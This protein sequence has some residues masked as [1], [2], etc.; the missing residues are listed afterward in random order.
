MS[1]SE[2]S[3]IE[4]ITSL[5]TNDGFDD[6]ALTDLKNDRIYGECIFCAGEILGRMKCKIFFDAKK[7]AVSA[8][9]IASFRETFSSDI[10]RGVYFTY[11]EAGEDA[12][13]EASKAGNRIVTIYTIDRK[14]KKKSPESEGKVNP[15]RGDAAVEGP[16]GSVPLET[17]K[18]AKAAAI[19]F[20]KKNGGRIERVV[21]YSSRQK[22]RDE[23]WIN[24]DTSF[25]HENWTLILNDIEKHELVLL[26]IPKNTFHAGEDEKG[27]KVRKD[28][29]TYEIKI[30]RE[31][32]TDKISKNSFKE[33]ILEVYK[34]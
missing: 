19:K 24:P 14:V 33:Y 17:A 13:K 22:E 28:K 32:M 6:I 3:R 18:F 23:Y 21:S 8:A 11:A 7:T 31:T 4:L 2:S 12:M 20:I 16:R 5:L 25:V 15:V 1:K 34:Y 9:D 30:K 10:E 29:D 27:L 26:M